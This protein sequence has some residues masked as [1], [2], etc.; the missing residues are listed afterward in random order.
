[1]FK[2]NRPVERPPAEYRA[3]QTQTG[4][5][6]Q[7]ELR[8]LK[9]IHDLCRH[10]NGMAAGTRYINGC[11]IAG[12]DTVVVP[13]R[14]AWPSERERQELIQHEW[15]HARGWRHNDDG[16]GT[17]PQSLKPKP[18]IGSAWGAR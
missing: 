6:Q 17:S 1:M 3:G 10:W 2:P 8:D 13:A 9:A 4:S 5:T 12:L 14:G 11:Y 7:L 16:R 18:L 15:A